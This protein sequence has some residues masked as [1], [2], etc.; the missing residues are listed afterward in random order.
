MLLIFTSVSEAREI[1]WVIQAGLSSGGDKIAEVRFDDG[2]K[3]T[4]YG[5]GT[6]LIGGGILVDTPPRQLYLSDPTDH[7][8]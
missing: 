4:I 1:E 7:Q 8:L 2:T 6:Y 5:G 3:E